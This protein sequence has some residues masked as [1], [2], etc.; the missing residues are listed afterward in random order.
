MQASRSSLILPALL[1]L[2]TS[3]AAQFG[4]EDTIPWG[5]SLGSPGT[6]GRSVAL[7]ATGDGQLDLF[8]R[9]G[10]NNDH[11]VFFD[12]IWQGSG[13][14]DTAI[15]CNDFDAAPAQGPSGIAALAFV[16]SGGLKL[17]QRNAMSSS[18]FAFETPT[19]LEAGSWAGAKML[20][21]ADL[22]GTGGLDY[23]GV[24]AD[25]QSLLLRSNTGSGW[26]TT[27]VNTGRDI[28]DI[29]LLNWTPTT[30]W[31][32]AVLSSQGVD[33]RNL[34]LNQADSVV[35]SGHTSTSIARIPAT[36]PSTDYLAWIG[37]NLSTA[38]TD[39]AVLHRI[40]PRV[41]NLAELSSWDWSATKLTTVDFN[42]DGIVDVLVTRGSTRALWQMLNSGTSSTPP[43]FDP[44][45][46]TELTWTSSMQHSGPPVA[47][48]FEC[49]LNVMDLVVP[50]YSGTNAELA[51]FR[52]A[53]PL[54][55]TGNDL[56]RFAQDPND[57]VP[58]E[59]LFLES[60]SQTTF[61]FQ[62]M[63]NFGDEVLTPPGSGTAENRH[64]EVTIF[65]GYPGMTNV[66]NTQSSINRYWIDWPAGGVQATD[67]T[68][69]GLYVSLPANPDPPLECAVLPRFLE[70]RQIRVDSAGTTVIESGPT[71]TFG[72]IRNVT[73]QQTYLP[74]GGF[75]EAEL[76]TGSTHQN[77]GCEDNSG[78]NPVHARAIVMRRKPNPITNTPILLP[79]PVPA[80]SN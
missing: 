16:D 6:L 34:S 37:T 3:A 59:V 23:V 52:K 45:Q 69:S 40:A 65:T 10:T 64:L 19:T 61:E 20:R 31:E 77:F 33:I 17:L 9:A 44:T 15:T 13:G 22:R 55:L 54:F 56:F 4:Y 39:F 76:L 58:P 66:Y 2:S 24:K 46:K 18:S 51:L 26:V 30:N 11:L 80:S 70:V 5:A 50:A 72:H 25:G 60:P 27:E 32:I 29:V 28:L 7:E 14:L 71:Y 35:V 12:G 49:S 78:I 63:I 36:P 1:L 62:F 43:A 41:D 67:L 79:L 38:L 21:V 48:H 8:V 47:A 73:D 57:P 42:N 75:E 74:S 68:L 53:M